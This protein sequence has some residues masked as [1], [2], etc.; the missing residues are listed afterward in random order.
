MLAFFQLL[1]FVNLCLAYGYIG[2]N[3]ICVPDFPGFENGIH[4]VVMGYFIITFVQILSIVGDKYDAPFM[5]WRF[6]CSVMDY[7]NNCHLYL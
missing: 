6:Y 7:L 3:I 4:A 1:A 5:V 2:Q